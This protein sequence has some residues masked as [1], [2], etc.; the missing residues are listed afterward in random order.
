MTIN[1]AITN[2]RK[3][4]ASGDVIEALKT[5]QP[6]SLSLD[7][8]I[9]ALTEASVAKW[10]EAERAAS[11]AYYA[12]QYRTIGLALNCLA[13]WDAENPD[14]ILAAQAILAMTTNDVRSLKSGG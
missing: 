5:V 3:L 2:A 8:A 13:Y 10:G 11:A 7:G 12:G 9:A 14:R 1:T 4:G 6:S